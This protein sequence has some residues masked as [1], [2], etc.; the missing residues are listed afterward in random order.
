MS[1][2]E[3]MATKKIRILSSVVLPILVLGATVGVC[4]LFQPAETTPLFWVNLVYGLIL[5]AIFFGWMEWFR[6][7]QEGTTPMLSMILGVY[8]GWYVLCGGLCILGSA[9]ASFFIAVQLK[10]YLAALI[11]LTIAWCIPA[12]FIAEADSNH[13]ERM[14]DAEE[15]RQKLLHR[16]SNK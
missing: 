9:I 8:A 10:W 16:N 11:V 12:F 13:A 1:K 6:R 5:E 7:P 3:I 15:R 2:I 4:L 14:E